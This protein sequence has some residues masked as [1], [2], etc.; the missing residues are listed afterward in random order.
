VSSW[1]PGRRRGAA[2]YEVYRSKLGH[3]S[4][5]RDIPLPAGTSNKD[6]TATQRDGIPEVRVRMSE[7][8]EEAVKKVPISHG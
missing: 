7:Q 3:G 6:V 1:R 8:H 5:T 4:F 2:G